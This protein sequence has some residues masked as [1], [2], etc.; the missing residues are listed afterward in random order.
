[1][2]SILTHKQTKKTKLII[3]VL[4]LIC[5]LG[6]MI[7]AGLYYI[8]VKEYSAGNDAYL[9]I[10]ALIDDQETL[11]DEESF[12]KLAQINNDLIGW[13]SLEGTQIDYPLVHS[14]NN[15]Y[16]L[17]HIFTKEKNKLGTI[18]I[19]YRNKADLSDKNTIIY[20]HNMHDGSMFAT[21]LNYTEQD[22]YDQ[23]PVINLTI[24]ED[25]YQVLL[26]AGILTDGY[27]DYAKRSFN[28]GEFMVYINDI[29]ALSTFKSTIMINENDQIITF[30]TC[31]YNVENGRYA[32][33]GKLVATK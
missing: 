28:D 22:F 9:Q 24:G 31:S 8:S 3:K 33:F 10:Q 30:S 23:H 7:S 11:N 27:S 32:L 20:G 14:D 29:I 2:R 26:F 16:Y 19:D 4:M 18:F 25:E 17:T 5:L 13:I 6:V 15:E 21:L 1:M 12:T